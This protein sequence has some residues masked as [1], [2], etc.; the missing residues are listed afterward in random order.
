MRGMP[1][2][3]D[4]SMGARVRRLCTDV[5]QIIFGPW[6]IRPVLL[7]FISF[8]VFQYASGVVAVGRNQV[9]LGAGSGL[10]VN[11]ARAI[12]VGVVFALLLRIYRKLTGRIDLTRTGY[13]IILFV[14]GVSAGISRYVTLFNAD[15]RDAGQLVFGAVRGI[16]TLMI[17]TSAL[18][19][20]DS[21]LLQQ[22]RQTDAALELVRTQRSSV[23]D[24]EERAR[25]SIA[26]ILHD[27]VQAGLVAATLQLKQIATSLRGE[28]SA[29]LESVI[30]DLEAMRTQDVRSASRQLS[31]DLRNITVTQALKVLASTYEPAIRTSINLDAL[32]E[33]ARLRDPH[34]PLR[35]GAYRIVEQSLLNAAVHGGA[36]S[37]SVETARIEDDLVLTIS[38]NG[39]GLGPEPITHGAGLTIIDAWSAAMNGTWVIEDDSTGTR[40]T[41]RVPYL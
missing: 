18:G 31:P 19:I 8:V 25:Q 34:S 22:I 17:L 4:S 15:D 27:R 5:A 20:A 35:L 1:M 37:V 16:V 21:R 26:S 29:R 30:A 32:E 28:E 11:L 7:G 36:T 14:V 38:D 23:L 3:T 24:A 9:F 40:V 39:Q 10:P 2:S 12:A 33:A 41:V 6:P 13:L